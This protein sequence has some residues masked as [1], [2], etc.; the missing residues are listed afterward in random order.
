VIVNLDPHHRQECSYEVPLWEFG[1][2]DD[3]SVEVE[4]LLDGTHFTLNGKTQRIALDP[5]ERTAVIW[6]LVP[7]N[8][9]KGAP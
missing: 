5:H 9:W 8:I 4:D 6:R 1:L 7:P 2:Q 3:A